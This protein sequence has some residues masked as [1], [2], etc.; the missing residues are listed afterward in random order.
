[1]PIFVLSRTFSLYT[2][3]TQPQQPSS[4]RSNT[5]TIEPS[6][7]ELY[8]ACLLLHYKSKPKRYELIIHTFILENNGPHTASYQGKNVCYSQ[9]HGR[10]SN[11]HS[12]YKIY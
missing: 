6:K 8:K 1:M 10:K 7:Y 9:R 11:L 5:L 12:I 3:P 2:N 4:I